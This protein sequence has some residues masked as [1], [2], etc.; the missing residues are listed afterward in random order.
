MALIDISNPCTC[1]RTYQ[2][3]ET[4]G[5]APIQ[6]AEGWAIGSLSTQAG[7]GV[8]PMT[9]DTRYLVDVRG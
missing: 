3:F 7:H 4:R 2:G 8:L 5:D 1:T 9:S 6:S